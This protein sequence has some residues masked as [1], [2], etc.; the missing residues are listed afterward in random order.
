MLAK[1]LFSIPEHHRQGIHF[2][3]D[4]AKFARAKMS[5][6]SLSGLSVQ[7]GESPSEWGVGGYAVS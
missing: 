2:I 3:H 6:R 5:K 7:S 1:S 4:K